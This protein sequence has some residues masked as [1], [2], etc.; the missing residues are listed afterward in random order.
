M[1]KLSMAFLGLV[2]MISSV[3]AHAVATNN[4]TNNFTIDRVGPRPDVNKTFVTV[5]GSDYTYS[6]QG[7]NVNWF[8]L[9]DA[10][11]DNK[12]VFSTLLTAYS[13][14]RQVLFHVYPGTCQIKFVETCGAT[15][16]AN[17]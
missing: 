13:T 2:A 17:F 8:E 11:D 10:D 7:N 3:S 12:T 14:G 16:C 9:L 5:K 15:S 1:K 4:W 6:C